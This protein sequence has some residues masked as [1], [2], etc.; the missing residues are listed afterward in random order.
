MK[1]TVF[2]QSI[3]QKIPY[4]GEIR[5]APPEYA[6]AWAESAGYY[7]AY[8]YLDP[9]V[10]ATAAGGFAVAT[11]LFGQYVASDVLPYAMSGSQS[12]YSIGVKI[13][14]NPFGKK[15]IGSGL[16][17][18]GNKQGWSPDI[19]FPDPTINTYSQVVAKG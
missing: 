18:V 14:N 5:P 13:Y 4:Q 1:K 10:R 7:G 17:Y 16:G 3:K 15:A 2:E 12:L 9:I 8:I 11:G 6:K 19:N